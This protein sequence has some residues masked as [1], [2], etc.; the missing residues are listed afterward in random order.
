MGAMNDQLRCPF[1]NKDLSDFTRALAEK[2]VAKCRT[3]LKPK[4]IY[5]DRK[6]GRPTNKEK[7]E[8]LK[9]RE[10]EDARKKKDDL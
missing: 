5:S 9:A 6:R 4:H 7:A 1:C 10:E 2:H 8:F 3:L